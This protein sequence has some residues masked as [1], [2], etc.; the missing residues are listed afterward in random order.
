[1]MGL[2]RRAPRLKT[3]ADYRPPHRHPVPPYRELRTVKKTG[4]YEMT[5]KGAILHKGE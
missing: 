5:S 3:Y 4:H 2:F 1:M